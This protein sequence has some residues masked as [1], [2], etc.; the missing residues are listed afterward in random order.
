M[1]FEEWNQALFSVLMYKDTVVMWCQ[2][3][4]LCC[5]WSKVESSLFFFCFLFIFLSVVYDNLSYTYKYHHTLSR[6]S[7]NTTTKKKKVSVSRDVLTCA[8]HFSTKNGTIIWI[9]IQHMQHSQG[10]L[11]SFYNAH[12]IGFTLLLSPTCGQH[13]R[14]KDPH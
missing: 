7:A 13:V 10:W 2:H 4:H 8:E 14:R 1:Y 5:Q 6:L 12:E 9:K 11:S 3:L